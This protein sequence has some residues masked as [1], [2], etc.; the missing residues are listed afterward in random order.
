MYNV[1]SKTIYLYRLGQHLLFSLAN[2]K[3]ALTYN[4]MVILCYA[5]AN[6]NICIYGGLRQIGANY[7]G[8]L[9]IRINIPLLY[10]IMARYLI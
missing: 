10:G 2:E 4:C 7:V 8:V 9:T 3:F 6:G 5:K 1:E